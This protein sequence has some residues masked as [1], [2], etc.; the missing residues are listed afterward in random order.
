MGVFWVGGAKKKNSKILRD[1]EEWGF[2][3]TSGV[4]GVYKGAGTLLVGHAQRT[5][6]YPCIRQ[7]Q[8]KALNEDHMP[9]T[10]SQK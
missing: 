6:G 1:N 4:E 2:R 5:T 3:L 10:D 9:D 8:G 7:L